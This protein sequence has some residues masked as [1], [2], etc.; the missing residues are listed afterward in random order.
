MNISQFLRRTAMAHGEL[1]AVFSGT[2]RV[3]DYRTLEDRVARLA[4]YLRERCG[5]QVGDRVAIFAANCTEFLEA[6]HAIHWAGAVS[7]PVNFKLHSKELA[8]VLENSGARVVCVSQALRDSAR[9]AG[10]Q[11]DDLLVFASPAWQSAISAGERLAL[12]DRQP[13]DLASLFY[14]SGTTGRPKGVMQTHRNLMA[15]T[16]A[17]FTDVDDIQTHDAIVYAAPMSHGAGL[18]NYAHMLRGARHVVPASGGFD[19][20]ELVELAASVGHL[21]M[22]AAPTMVHRLVEHVRRSGADVSG[23]KT[24]V[25]GGGPM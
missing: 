2:Q 5:V 25:Y 16:M 1:P 11:P 12:Q 8:Y 20:A 21:S 24:I 18:Y 17:Y 13:D 4:G 3:C 14:T 9:E 22:F 10:A 19:P 6:L 7:V 23:F 15:A